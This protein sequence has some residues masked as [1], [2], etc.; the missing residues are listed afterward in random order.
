MP[1]RPAEPRDELGGRLPD[2]VVHFARVLRCA[3]LVLPTDRILLALEGLAVAA[4]TSREEFRAVL[5]ASLIDRAEHV[6]LFDQAFEVFWRD[7]D[8][9]GRLMRMLLP[10]AK[11]AA[12]PPP[13]PENRRLAEAIA[14]ARANT[15]SALERIQ[16]D[17][18]LSA[19]DREALR[20]ADFDT[21]SAAEWAQARRLL[22]EI[23]AFFELRPTRRAAPARRG[24]GVDLRAALRRAARHGGEALELPRRQP[25]LRADPLIAL[26]D[27]SGS[28]ARY[29][30]MFLHFMHGLVRGDSRAS[31][32]VFGTRLTPVTRALRAADPD[33]AVAAVVRAVAD[34]QGGTRIAAALGQFNRHWARRTGIARATV[35]LVTDGL[36][37]G[38]CAAL[39]RE[40]AWLAR[41]CRRL[42]WLN[43]L[44]RYA[45]F[46]P[47]A[48]GVRALLP[49]VDQHL[50]V[51]DLDSL[52]QLAALL[53]GAAIQGASRGTHRT[54]QPSR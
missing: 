13:W 51:H 9:Q 15:E 38:D 7:P 19:S 8:W 30:R 28:M 31:A 17:A 34:W 22:A 11:A 29:S 26:V 27:V 53:A 48:A 32:F 10:E 44:L 41:S 4:P 20:K 46:E 12:H 1:S 43:P 50:P 35:L 6:L 18:V 23:Q 33:L 14:P 42:V 39:S 54:A 52:D 3:G 45:G 25:G 2:K 24:R 5:G 36:E 16:I 49:W 47:R 40:A 37:Q 21:M